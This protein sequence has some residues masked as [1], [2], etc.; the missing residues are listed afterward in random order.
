MDL[1]RDR[2]LGIICYK[3]YLKPQSKKRQGRKKA[4]KQFEIKKEKGNKGDGEAAASEAGK[5][6]KRCWKIDGKTYPKKGA[7]VW[8]VANPAEKSGNL[9]VGK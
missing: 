1:M 3:C 2:V 6:S 9:N 7:G 5:K 4:E 8:T